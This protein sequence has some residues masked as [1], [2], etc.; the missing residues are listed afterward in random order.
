MGSSHDR[1]P[2]RCEY[3]QTV[4]SG[5]VVVI[6]INRP[7]GRGPN[8]GV[9]QAVSKIRPRGRGPKWV[10]FKPQSLSAHSGEVRNGQ[11]SRFRPAT[12]RGETP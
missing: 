7:P 10:A 1:H 2:P 8:V 4:P 11:F 9:F 6:P 12:H 5:E 3:P